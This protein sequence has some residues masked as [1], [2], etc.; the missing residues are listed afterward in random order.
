MALPALS[1]I[2]QLARRVETLFEDI[3][4]LV[5]GLAAARDE[6]RNLEKRISALES[7]EELLAPRYH[8]SALS[9]DA[10]SPA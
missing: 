9:A 6:L 10:V 7:R 4:K 5:Q 2:W 1:A 8:E 3:A